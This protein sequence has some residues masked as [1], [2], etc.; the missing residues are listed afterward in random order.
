MRYCP[1][2]TSPSRPCHAC[3]VESTNAAIRIDCVGASAIPMNLSGIGGGGGGPAGTL[4]VARTT[5]GGGSGGAG[6]GGGGGFGLNLNRFRSPEIGF[7][8]SSSSDRR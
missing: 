1:A 7:G 8:R 2:T 6:G 4:G 3:P 5:G